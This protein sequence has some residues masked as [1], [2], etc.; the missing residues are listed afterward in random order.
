MRFIT[1]NTNQISRL[2][3]NEYFEITNDTRIELHKDGLFLNCNGYIFQSVSIGL[4]FVEREVPNKHVINYIQNLICEH[5]NLRPCEVIYL[6]SG[7]D[8]FEFKIRFPS[9][10]EWYIVVCESQRARSNTIACTNEQFD[11]NI[12]ASFIGLYKRLGNS[13][14]YFRWFNDI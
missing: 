3:K 2:I 6:D 14:Y 9:R 10:Q 4:Q 12:N 5:L 13:S 1:L 7:N 11:V 8:E